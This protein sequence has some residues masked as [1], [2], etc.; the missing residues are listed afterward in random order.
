MFLIVILNVYLC[1]LAIPSE[2]LNINAIIIK[3]II[4]FMTSLLIQPSLFILKYHLT[5]KN[6]ALIDTMTV[7]KDIS[8][9]PI[10]GLS[11]IPYLYRTPAANGIA[12]AL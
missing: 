3:I 8:T 4:L 6:F 9:A 11:N 12:N 1:T 7:L 5:F 10:A 2:Q